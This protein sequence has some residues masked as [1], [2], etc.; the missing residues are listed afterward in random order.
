MSGNAV[1]SSLIALETGE[2][3]CQLLRSTRSLTMRCLRI[4]DATAVISRRSCLAHRHRTLQ[5]VPSDHINRAPYIGPVFHRQGPLVIADLWLVKSPVSLSRLHSVIFVGL[6]GIRLFI[7]V[8]EEKSDAAKRQIRQLGHSL[9]R[10][11]SSAS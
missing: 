5:F 4:H 6:L 8:G 10:C 11:V 3:R 1:F 9:T 7:C 2:L